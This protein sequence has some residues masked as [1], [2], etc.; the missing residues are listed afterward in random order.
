VSQ[1]IAFHGEAHIDLFAQS[2]A[3]LFQIMSETMRL[4]QFPF[5][6]VGFLTNVRVVPDHMRSRL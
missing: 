6:F 1:L 5:N 2:S 3:F 4:G